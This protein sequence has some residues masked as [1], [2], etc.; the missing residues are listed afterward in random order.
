MP[1]ETTKAS[2]QNRMPLGRG[3]YCSFPQ[4]IEKSPSE[5]MVAGHYVITQHSLGRLNNENVDTLPP[6]HGDFD[7]PPCWHSLESLSA[8]TC[9]PRELTEGNVYVQ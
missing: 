7:C 1:G 9:S 8:A 6:E 5:E 4:L 3:N 2:A